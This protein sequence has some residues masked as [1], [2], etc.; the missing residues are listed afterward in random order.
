[1]TY[2]GAVRFACDG[3]AV[4]ESAFRIWQSGQGAGITPGGLVAVHGRLEA[5][6]DD[7]F[8]SLRRKHQRARGVCCL[9]GLMLDGRRKSVEPMAA[10]LG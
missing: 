8:E 1:L 10:R 3:W 7:V 9:R 6:A 5:F 2:R 4:S